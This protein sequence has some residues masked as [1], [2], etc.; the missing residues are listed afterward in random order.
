MEYDKYDFELSPDE[1]A[2]RENQIE[3]IRASSKKLLFAYVVYIALV[4]VL[5]FTPFIVPNN[6]ESGVYL[7]F[8]LFIL[9]VPSIWVLYHSV[10]LH[11]DLTLTELYS[12]TLGGTGTIIWSL[13]LLPHT[14]ALTLPI[15]GFFSSWRIPRKLL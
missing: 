12:S 8:S 3:N 9:V 4:V 5:V 15:L 2:E 7:I 6:W 10:Q 13:I 11:R 1:I 14:L